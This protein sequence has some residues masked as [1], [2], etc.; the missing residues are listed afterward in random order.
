VVVDF[1]AGMVRSL[2][3]DRPVLSKLATERWQGES[4]RS[5]S[6]ITSNWPLLTVSSPFHAALL[7][8][9]T[10]LWPGVG[11]QSKRDLKAAIDRVL[12]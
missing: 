12:A 10:G 2:Q 1:W 8:G 9:R 5:T 11:A 6:T 4:A 7:Q 3:N